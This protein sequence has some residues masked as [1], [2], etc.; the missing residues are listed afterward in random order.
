MLVDEEAVL[1]RNRSEEEVSELA[2]RAAVHEVWGAAQR[3]NQSQ[4]A[5]TRLNKFR[6]V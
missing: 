1:V 5:H 4:A 3:G 6:V 2:A